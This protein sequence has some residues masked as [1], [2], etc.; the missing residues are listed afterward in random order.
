MSLAEAVTSVS[1]PAKPSSP[2]A[3]SWMR[4]HA[5]AQETP[6]A[7]RKHPRKSQTQRAPSPGKSAGV[8]HRTQPMPSR[9]NKNSRQGSAKGGPRSQPKREMSSQTL[10]IPEEHG[11][12]QP[13]AH[14]QLAMLHGEDEVAVSLPAKGMKVITSAERPGQ[15]APP[16]SP[17]A[18]LYSPPGTGGTPLDHWAGEL[19]DTTA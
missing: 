10:S 12:T 16:P 14:E 17:A 5:A 3:S 8:D 1:Q 9:A 4:G 2:T 6:P 11:H 13:Y 7:G 15:D 18:N 19:Q